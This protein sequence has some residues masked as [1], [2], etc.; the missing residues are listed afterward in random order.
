M[1][2]IGS[3]PLPPPRE[4]R[5][6]T[7]QEENREEHKPTVDPPFLRLDS[8]K[9]GRSV[10]I[11]TPPQKKERPSR[12][13]KLLFDKFDQV[14]HLGGSTLV[15]QRSSST[16]TW[17]KNMFPHSLRAFGYSSQIPGFLQYPGLQ[18]RQNVMKPHDLFNPK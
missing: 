2:V 12:T 5:T 15:L 17:Q 1:K 3:I 6:T 16:R 9:H 10:P 11:R 8:V 13:S 18:K 14:W 7:L 4:R